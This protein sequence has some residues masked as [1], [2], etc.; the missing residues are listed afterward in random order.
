MWIMLMPATWSLL[1]RATGRAQ[2]ATIQL[3][4]SIIPKPNRILP[5]TNTLR[6]HTHFIYLFFFFFFCSLYP[7]RRKD[8]QTIQNYVNILSTIESE[9]TEKYIILRKKSTQTSVA[10]DGSLSS[11][12]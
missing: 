4:F 11:L 6:L 3:I 7:R 9:G 5:I 2:P 8:S 1:H 10:T 12:S